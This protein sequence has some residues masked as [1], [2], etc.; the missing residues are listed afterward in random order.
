MEITKK[1]SKQNFEDSDENI[2]D[3]ASKKVQAQ[4]F[5]MP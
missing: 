4:D 3:L 1:P 5:D 2:F